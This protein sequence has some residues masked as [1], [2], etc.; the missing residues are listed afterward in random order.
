MIYNVFKN[1]KYIINFYYIIFF[2]SLLSI[3]IFSYKD[4]GIHIDELYSRFL[5]L[6][7]LNYVSNLFFPNFIFD[8]QTNNDLPDLDTFF[9]KSNSVSYELFLVFFENILNIEKTNN[10]IFFRHLTN[11]LFFFTSNIA[12]FF[13]I[14]ILYKS[15]FL[16][17]VGTL[18]LFFSPRIFAN[19]FYNSKD[20]VFLSL[21]IISLFFLVKILKKI[22]YKRIFF[23]SI[24]S[25]FS[26]GTRILGI[27]IPFL[28]ILF[29][30]LIC[31]Q[32]KGYFL[33]TYKYLI[34]FILSICFFTVLFWPFLWESPL[35]N[36]IYSLKFYSQFP[37]DFDIFYLGNFINS[38]FLPWHYLLV[39]IFAT[40]HP[41]I[42]FFFLIGFFSI[43]VRFAKRFILVDSKNYVN[44][45]WKGNNEKINFFLLLCFLI[46][47][48]VIISLNFVLYNDWR[49]LYF[50]FPFM[51]L[52]SL[53]GIN[54]LLITNPIKKINIV[55]KIIPIL[56]IF[57]NIYNVIIFHPFQN[58][59]FNYFF[60]KKANSMF[61][62]DYFGLG[63]L[64]TLQKIITLKPNKE[65]ITIGLKSMANL[66]DTKEMLNQADKDR[67][68][69]TGPDVSGQDF[70]FTNYYYEYNP[71]LTDKYMIP[72]N[73]KKVF[74]LKRGNV[75]INEL[76]MKK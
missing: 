35:N 23:F 40:T 64:E 10:I 44:E 1:K 36:L 4:F 8:F 24:F 20:L 73:Y 46:P 66:N 25:A 48:A 41:G 27:Y 14:K 59:Y 33:N 42:T 45:I 15:N 7:S 21:I 22:T 3:G 32:K 30:L 29:Y 6:V 11:F 51:V 62:I 17:S 18:F 58:T 28:F 52:I 12:F 31:L 19:S 37:M 34:F 57:T 75:I 49:I 38:N 71:I 69:I 60:E 63:N 16:P 68:L 70:I 74:S 67:L 43:F 13:T 47:I 9:W 2:G 50:V 39:W 5:G 65:K 55:I 61:V 53:Y 72:K 76:Y 54:F 56:F 26:I